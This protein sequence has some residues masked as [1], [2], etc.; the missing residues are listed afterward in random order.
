MADYLKATSLSDRSNQGQLIIKNSEGDI[1]KVARALEEAQVWDKSPTQV[2][3]FSVILAPVGDVTVFFELPT[4]YDSARAYPLLV[5]MPSEASI[6]NGIRD[7]LWAQIFDDVIVV[8]PSRPIEGQFHK[9]PESAGESR[10]LMRAIRQRFHIDSTRVF[11]EGTGGSGNTAWMLTVNAP[12]QFAG[13]AAHGGYLDVPFRKQ[14]YPILVP[15]LGKLT[16]YN[17]WWS[18]HLPN[19][20][21]ADKTIAACNQAIEEIDQKNNLGITSQEANRSG[22]SQTQVLERYRELTTSSREPIPTKLSHYFRY[23]EQG[24]CAWLRQTKFAGDV[25]TA[26]QL[27]ILPGP[28][29]DSDQYITD[30]LKSLL[31]YMGGAIEG[32]TIRIETRRCADIELLLYENMVDFTKPVVVYING[33]KRHDRIVKP[34][35]P[36]LLEEAYDTFDFQ[37]LVFAKLAFDI[38]EDSTAPTGK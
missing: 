13:V 32:N 1:T 12:D 24:Q 14:L 6:V 11:L 17:L 23:P 4:S 18:A 30:V 37:R 2:G 20:N 38:K 27:S 35:I 26:D 28:E 21:E 29:V 34:S 8:F 7:S 25:W 36:T 3:D 10:I 5:Q 9:T 33:K 16:F 31:A 15:N 19:S 22:D